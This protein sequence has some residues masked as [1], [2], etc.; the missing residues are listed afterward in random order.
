VLTTALAVAAAAL[1]GAAPARAAA[2]GFDV[3]ITEMPARFTAGADA[4][5]VTVVASAEAGRECEKVRW[6]MLLEVDGV[7]LGQVQVDRI[8]EDGSFP[9][10]VRTEGDTA[11]L[12]DVRLDPGRLCPGRTVTA[13]YQVAFADE[14]PDG[15]VTFQAQAFDANAR[16][17]EEASAST[18]VVSGDGDAS[19]SPS[20]SSP[21][22]EESEEAGDAAGPSAPP[23]ASGD[24][25]ANRAAAEGGVPSLLG[26]GLVVGAV[27]VF[28]GVSLLLRLRLRNRGAPAHR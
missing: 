16:L 27:L 4:R 6:S 15:R 22:A 25:A 19:P 14:A 3:T 7:D 9:L 24:L 23:A 28:L 17:L 5:T 20:P 11:R 13:R 1:T 26:P 18:R 12:T 8:E 2:D 10:R 21:E